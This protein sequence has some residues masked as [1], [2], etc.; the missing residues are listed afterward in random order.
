M[1]MYCA[2]SQFQRFGFSIKEEDVNVGRG[3]KKKKKHRLT[4]CQCNN[5][6][7]T[8][9]RPIYP[10]FYSKDYHC[11]IFRVRLP[12]QQHALFVITD[13]MTI[14]R[15]D[16]FL[17]I[18]DMCSTEWLWLIS[19]MRSSH[20]IGSKRIVGANYGVLHMLW[21]YHNLV[22]FYVKRY[23]VYRQTLLITTNKYIIILYKRGLV[24][25]TSEPLRQRWAGSLMLGLT[26][27]K[28]HLY[29]HWL[30]YSNEGEDF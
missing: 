4:S 21:P 15:C 1:I 19:L 25:L 5:S 9:E 22:E 26:E 13:C 2:R 29:M 28:M 11:W 7:I 14:G 3:K 6:F 16:A 30:L 20:Q 10:K 18:A 12:P 23:T 8:I 24:H 27:A 17:W